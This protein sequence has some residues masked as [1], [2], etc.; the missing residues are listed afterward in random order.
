MRV[1]Y[2]NPEAPGRMERCGGP[3]RTGFCFPGPFNHGY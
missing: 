2:A 3:A 1:M